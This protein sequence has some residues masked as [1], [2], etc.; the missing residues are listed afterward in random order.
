MIPGLLPSIDSFPQRRAQLARRQGGHQPVDLPL[1]P[2]QIGRDC[3]PLGLE[4]RMALRRSFRCSGSFDWGSYDFP[5]AD[6]KR[7]RSILFQ[8]L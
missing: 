8:P 4:I 1:G 6:Q 5:L 3:R 7:I 2:T